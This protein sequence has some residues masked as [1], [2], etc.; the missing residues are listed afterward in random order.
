MKFIKDMAGI[1]SAGS[2]ELANA[3]DPM[4]EIVI[5]TAAAQDYADFILNYIDKDHK[6]ISHRLYRQHCRY[7][8]GVYVKD[9]SLLGRDLKKTI[10]VDNIKDNFERQSK[11]GIEILTWLSDPADR[12]L[13]KLGLF[14]TELRKQ[15]VVD[16]RDHVKAYTDEKWRCGSPSKRAFLKHAVSS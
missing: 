16:V 12:E 10:I 9:L 13:H 5:F 3:S 14:L 15:Q 1:C 11:N 4:Y 8:D 7:D 2:T 6:Y